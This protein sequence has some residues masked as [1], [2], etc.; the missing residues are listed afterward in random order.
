MDE[1]ARER[2]IRSASRLFHIRSY[3]GVGVKELCEAADVRRGSFYYYFPSKEALV[4]AVLEYEEED[5]LTRV[6]NPAFEDGG[7]PLERFEVFLNRLYEY[8]VDR[9]LTEGGTV[10]GCPIANLGQELGSQYEYLRIQANAILDRFTHMF[11]GALDEARDAGDLAADVDT[12]KTAKRVRAYTQGL[13]ELGKLRGD[14]DV[15]PELGL[16]VRG[17]SVKVSPDR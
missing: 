2:L 14:N 5:L 11:H 8:Q 17:L 3:S 4:S 6:F 15:L 16:D 12:E 13:L 10:G 9:S 7:A 1:T